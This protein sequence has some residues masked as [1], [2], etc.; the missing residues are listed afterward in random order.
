MYYLF[1]ESD[2][3]EEARGQQ[4]SNTHW[5]NSFHKYTY[6]QFIFL[7]MALIFC[8]TLTDNATANASP[9]PAS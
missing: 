5:P 8:A 4:V 6:W 1:M 2:D 9:S 7:N 3:D